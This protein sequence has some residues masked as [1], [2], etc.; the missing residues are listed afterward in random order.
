MI[1]PDTKKTALADFFLCDSCI[2]LHKVKQMNQQQIM[3][4]LLLKIDESVKSQARIASG[5]FK[6]P[7]KNKKDSSDEDE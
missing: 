2:K 7:P 4:T 1:N 6:D 3:N 5:I